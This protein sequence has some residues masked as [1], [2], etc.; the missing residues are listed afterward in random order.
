MEWPMKNIRGATSDKFHGEFGSA[1]A[2]LAD[3]A[4]IAVKRAALRNNT[5]KASDAGDFL[6]ATDDPRIEDQNR[7][8]LIPE[9]PL[10]KHDTWTRANDTDDAVDGTWA[11]SDSFER[12]EEKYG[13]R[14]DEKISELSS[15]TQ[16]ILKLYDQLGG[17]IKR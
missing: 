11:S 10:T 15:I 4:K 13:E 8:S 17:F 7:A 6:R 9:M 3:L 14:K 5:A 2:G 12:A 16:P 1:I